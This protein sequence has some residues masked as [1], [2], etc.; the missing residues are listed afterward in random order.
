MWIKNNFFNPS[1][2]KIDGTNMVI[3][4]FTIMNGKSVKFRICYHYTLNKSSHVRTGEIEPGAAFVAYFF[5]RIAVYDDIDG[6]NKYPYLGTQEFYNDFCN[7]DAYVSVPENFVVWATGDLQNSNEVFNSRIQDRI[8]QAEINDAM[9]S[10]IDTA[11][12][13]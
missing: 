5:P 11:D 6:W 4:G 2:K 8:A 12:H 3:N 9:I 10:I 7:F 13:Q 1:G